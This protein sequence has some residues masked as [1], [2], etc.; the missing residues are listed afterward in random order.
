[1]TFT[2]V[3]T[4]DERRSWL[5]ALARFGGEVPGVALASGVVEGRRPP[6]S[7][8]NGGLWRRGDL[9]GGWWAWDADRLKSRLDAI[10]AYPRTRPTAMLPLRG[11]GSAGQGGRDLPVCDSWANP[12]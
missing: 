7:P 6:K 12:G 4:A 8:R 5:L 9:R 3:L 2:G 10:V 1:A 11:L